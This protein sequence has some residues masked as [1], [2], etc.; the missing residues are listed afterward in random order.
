MKVFT[1]QLAVTFEYDA[2]IVTVEVMLVTVMVAT[3]FVFVIPVL[4]EI[5]KTR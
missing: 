4:N 5:K 2:V 1:V 3:P